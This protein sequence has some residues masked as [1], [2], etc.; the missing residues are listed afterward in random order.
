[1]TGWSA[2]IT[3]CVYEQVDLVTARGYLCAGWANANC[4]QEDIL[5]NHTL[6]RLMSCAQALLS[7]V[8]GQMF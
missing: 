1:M 3:V 6:S 7:A 5:K 2:F 4:N 8:V